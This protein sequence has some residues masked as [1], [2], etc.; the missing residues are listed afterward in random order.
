LPLRAIDGVARDSMNVFD[1]ETLRRLIV[2]RTVG[3][4]NKFF[5]LAALALL[6][7][8]ASP[9]LGTGSAPAWQVDP[10]STDPAGF[11]MSVIG[12]PA[13]D[14]AIGDT[15]TTAIGVGTDAVGIDDS[16]T[17]PPADPA[18]K[19]PGHT[20]YVDNTPG[21]D[22]KATP[23]TTIQAGVDAS[24][25]GDTVK[26]CPGTY[27]EQVRI[28]GHVHDNLKLESLKPLQAVIQWPQ[29]VDFYPRA[30]VDFNTVDHVT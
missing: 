11:A 14:P 21:T 1:P 2:K 20:Y 17:N 10:D 9:V 12:L 8:V 13:P 19:D 16:L 6:T 3:I 26:V 28:N 23:Y 4:W 22:C 15:D 5:I 7:L 18:D 29:P 27:P 25:P 24:G 30:L